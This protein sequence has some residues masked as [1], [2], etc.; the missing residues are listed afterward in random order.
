MPIT[1]EGGPTPLTARQGREHQKYGEGGERLVAGCIPVR[2]KPGVEGPPGVEV[3]MITS[4]KGKGHVFPKGGWEVDES[5]ESAAKR[6]TVEEAGVRG[7]LE[8]PVLGIFPFYSNKAERL[9][10]AHAGRCVAYVFAMHVTEELPV[11]P[12]AA[13]RTREWLGLQEAFRLA[14]YDW[15]R[16]ALRAWLER[17]GWG[18]AAPPRD[19]AAVEPPPAAGPAGVLRAVPEAGAPVAAPDRVAVRS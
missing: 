19:D 1:S 14:R 2:F 7:R 15:M 18:A 6:E 10:T 3:L 13:Q 8:E 4:R 12:E 11:W 9:Q 5:L 17:K 16:D